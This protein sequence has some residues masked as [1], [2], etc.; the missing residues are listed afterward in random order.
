MKRTPLRHTPSKRDWQPAWD[1]VVAEACC[2]A[3]PGCDGHLEPAH[4]VPR[5]QIAVEAGDDPRAIIPLC[6]RH[7]MQAHHGELEMLPLLTLD[8]QAYAVSLIGI[9]RVRRYTIGRG[10]QA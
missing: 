7:H 4:V 5:S 10:G 8:E 3:A 9:E 6:R 2:R 1:K